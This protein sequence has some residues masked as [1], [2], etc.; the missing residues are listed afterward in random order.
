MEK[1][2]ERSEVSRGE[3]WKKKKR[4]RKEGGEE[5]E[6]KRIIERKV[7]AWKRDMDGCID[8]K[9]ERRRVGGEAD[10]V[11]LP[12]LSSPPFSSL[13]LQAIQVQGISFVGRYGRPIS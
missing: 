5:D 6:R 4:E 2:E 3:Q 11:Q 8:A 10:P 1:K 13:L 7:G 9:R 12:S